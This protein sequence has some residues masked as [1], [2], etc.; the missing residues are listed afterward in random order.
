LSDVENPNLDTDN[1]SR[2]LSSQPGWSILSGELQITGIEDIEEKCGSKCPIRRATA[3][4]LYHHAMSL[5][6]EHEL[7]HAINGHVPVLRTIMAMASIDECS[8]HN[9]GNTATLDRRVCYLEHQADNGA[10][11]S[12]I[13]RPVWQQLN[14]PFAVLSSR[15]ENLKLDIR[16]RVF[17]GAILTLF[18]MMS[19]V[20][21]ARGNVKAA[22]YWGT[23]PSSV[24]RALSF[25]LAPLAQI[26][27]LPE[28]VQP[29]IGFFINQATQS[30]AKDLL[31]LSESW[32]LFRPFRWTMRQD[33]YDSV[34]RP[35][36]LTSQEEAGIRELIVQHRYSRLGRKRCTQPV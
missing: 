12:H 29:E 26:D 15:D 4:R 33:M 16:L 5:V 28:D 25:V 1:Y 8:L 23:H 31:E 32:G 30:V 19:D 9:T 6:L 21:S 35:F 10:C 36:E 18:W 14:K 24:A 27:V 17:A 7:A 2:A 20:F 11:A 22:E 13:I 34:F 3:L